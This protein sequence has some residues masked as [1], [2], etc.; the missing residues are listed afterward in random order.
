MEGQEGLEPSTP[1][2]RGRC[3]NQLSYWPTFVDNFMMRCNEAFASPELVRAPKNY[4]CSLT[5]DNQLKLLVHKFAV[6][7]ELLYQENRF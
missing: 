7:T 1:C 5:L 4:K 6:K 2:L 3:S